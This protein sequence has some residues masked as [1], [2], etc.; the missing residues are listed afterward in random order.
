MTDFIGLGAILM[1]T[2]GSQRL[3]LLDFKEMNGAHT[4]ENIQAMIENMVNEYEFD[5]SKIHG[6]NTHR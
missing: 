1:M 2:D 3:C 5:K 4:A 6:T